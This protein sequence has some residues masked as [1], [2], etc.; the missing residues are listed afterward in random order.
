ML[1]YLFCSIL[2]LSLSLL[3]LLTEELKPIAINIQK[4]IRYPEFYMIWLIYMIWY[5]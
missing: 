4:M 2:S 1:Y 5:I 3:D